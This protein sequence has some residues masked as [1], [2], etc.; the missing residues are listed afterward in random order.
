MDS[1]PFSL[2]YGAQRSRPLRG[3]S[4]KIRWLTIL[5]VISSCLYCWTFTV[6]VLIF[7]ATGESGELFRRT[8]SFKAKSLF[9][10]TVVWFWSIRLVHSSS[11]RSEE[12]EVNQW[13]VNHYSLKSRWIVAKYLPRREAAR[14]IILKPLFTQIEKNNCFSIY[15]QSNLN[16]IREE[17][18]KKYDLIDVSN[19]AKV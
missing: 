17:T 5:R 14:S 12:L 2:K 4:A 3:G 15:T 18:I 16:K 1:L 8:Y 10:A 9:L 7:L 19:H 13:I 11:A 6:W